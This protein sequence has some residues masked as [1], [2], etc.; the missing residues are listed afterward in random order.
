MSYYTVSKRTIIALALLLLSTLTATSA[1]AQN[2]KASLVGEEATQEHNGGT[3]KGQVLLQGR[4]DQSRAV[5]VAT[6][7]SANRKGSDPA[8]GSEPFFK[9]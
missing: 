4:T 8:R 6:R 1:L 5:V 7:R 2:R 3:V 9:G